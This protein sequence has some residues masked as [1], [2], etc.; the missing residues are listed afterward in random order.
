MMPRVV[1]LSL[2]GGQRLDRK[3]DSFLN[4]LSKSRRKPDGTY[5]CPFQACRSLRL[6]KGYFDFDS[7]VSM[8]ERRYYKGYAGAPLLREM[9]LQMAD[10][11]GDRFQDLKGFLQ[12]NNVRLVEEPV[13]RNLSRI[14]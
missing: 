5:E 13:E 12:A 2:N 3:I 7:V 11:R 1:G 9:R 4:Y 14:M 6:V 10:V 8:F